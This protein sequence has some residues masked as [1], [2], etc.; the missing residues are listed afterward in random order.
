[1]LN[2]MLH[3]AD[4]ILVGENGDIVLIQR[5]GVTYHNFWALPGGTVDEGETIEEALIREMMEETGVEV[6]PKEILGVF[7]DPERDPRGRVISTVFI[8]KYKGDLEAGSDAGSVILCSVE[9]ALKKNLAFDHNFILQC[10]QKWLELKGTYWS[11][12][13]S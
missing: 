1:M 11:K 5:K 13:R 8:C 9:E 4:G 2:K 7:S 3:A 6:D 10:Y 12:K